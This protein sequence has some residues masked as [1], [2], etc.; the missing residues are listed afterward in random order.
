MEWVDRLQEVTGW[1]ASRWACDWDVVERELGTRLPCDYKELCERFGPG[2]FSGYM[3]VAPADGK[4]SITYWYR[5][6]KTKA[7]A[8]LYS[9]YGVYG[10][11]SRSGLL[12]WGTSEEAG[13]F[14]WFAD[15]GKDPAT[16]PIVALDDG[17]WNQ[18]EMSVSE[19]VCSVI[20]DSGF[21]PFAIP[22]PD[23]PRT[24]ERA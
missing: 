18:F 16:W 3:R 5:I 6:Y 23:W 7:V 2:L 10:R 11:D 22:L 8:S 17:R 24:F 15:S 12:L 21:E 4:Y 1:K 20:I 13:R 19:F 14:F 9:P